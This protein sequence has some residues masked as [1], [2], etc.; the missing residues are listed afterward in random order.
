MEMHQSRAELLLLFFYFF[1]CYFFSRYKCI[2]VFW[3]IVITDSTGLIWNTELC[4]H[5]LVEFDSNTWNQTSM[6]PCSSVLICLCVPVSL[7]TYLERSDMC[8]C[9]LSV[10]KKQRRCVFVFKVTVPFPIRDAAAICQEHWLA[11]GKHNITH[12]HSHRAS[13][14]IFQTNANA[15]RTADPSCNMWCATT[16]TNRQN[17]IRL[18]HV[19]EQSNFITV[20]YE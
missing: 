16:T 11:L 12:T 20:H 17:D 5:R 8:V 19:E 10:W 13:F 14:S 18:S 9:L 1:C 7:D 6:A 2:L 3:V 4:Q 15:M